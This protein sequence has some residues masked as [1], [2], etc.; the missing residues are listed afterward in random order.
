MFL[1]D[2][3]DLGQSEKYILSV[4]I[5]PDSFMFSI[6]EPG[7]GKS[8]CLKE[9][10]LSANDN[11]LGNIQRIIFDL[12]FLTQEY[13]Q[14]NVIIV[15]PDYTL[16]PAAYSNAKQAKSIYDF[17]HSKKGG[18]ILSGLLD[19]QD[20]VLSYSIEQEVFEFLSRNL[21]NPVFYHH[22][23]LMIHWFDKKSK[24]HANSSK[25]YLNFHSHF[26]D[27]I[28]FEGDKLIHCITFD[29]ENSSD[30]LYFILKIWENCHFDQ[31]NDNLFIVGK[32]E[33]MLIKSLEKY[34]KNIEYL[35]IP[36]EIF[37][38]NEDAQNAPLDLLT[39]AL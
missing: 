38:W 17:T 12:N 35:S 19:E 11:L 2:N 6:M 30:Q 26:M 13:K 36:S 4:R 8:Y 22:S 21:W 3:I 37:M 10:S 16:T 9:T 28:C 33:R 20:I 18:H 7:I 29:N 1:P 23:F 34:I 24:F 27:V 39:L 5:A 31:L 14:T 32:P 25:M 15:S